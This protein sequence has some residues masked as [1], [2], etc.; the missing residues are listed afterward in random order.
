MT[1]A[2]KT[3]ARPL[4]VRPGARYRCFGDGLCC[5]DIHGLGALT[6]KEAADVRRI[7]R[8]GAR[9]DEDF[10][11][12]MLRTAADGGCHFLLADM[13]C[14]IHAE[15]GPARK[16]SGCRT[17]PLGLTATPEGGR[18]T[19]EHRCP[20]RTLGERPPITPESAEGSICDASGRPDIDRRVGAVRLEKGRR[21]VPFA[22]WREV[23]AGVLERLAAGE[24]PAA[25]LEAEPFPRLRTGTWVKEAEELVEAKDGSRF[26]AAIA[27]FGD[28]ILHLVT[29]ARPRAPQRPWADG[30]DR[31]EARSPRPREA[32]EVFADWA[33]DVI[34]GLKWADDRSFALVRA[35]LA[36]RLA[37]AESVASRLIAGGARPDR[38]AA[39]AVM[40]VEV[41]GESEYW[42]SIVRRMAV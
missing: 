16:P 6:R 17:F 4:L 23:E 28:T 24:A 40:I 26:G 36:T 30:F 33:A 19:T 42:D 21:A 18:V 27:W 35:E 11:E 22:R 13:R 29:G 9:Y 37:I 1:T 10:E 3:L 7:D 5:H 14:G 34:W 38:A 25:V 2:P 8:R 12:V 41:V 31:A 32:R 39:E 20:C 15:H